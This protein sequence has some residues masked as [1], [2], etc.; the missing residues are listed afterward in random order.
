MPTKR[1]RR[2]TRSSN[3]SSATQTSATMTLDFTT[4]SGQ[5]STVGR[6]VLAVL[7][8]KAEEYALFGIRG[9]GKTIGILG[10]ILAH[11]EKH[12]QLGFGLPVPWLALRDSFANH[13]LT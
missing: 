11:A 7:E 6:F 9:A 12:R 13:K 2:A 1:R 4:A 3:S 8:A 10:A 5:V